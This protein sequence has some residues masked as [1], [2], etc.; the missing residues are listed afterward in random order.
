[1]ARLSRCSLGLR[2]RAPPN[3]TPPADR[4]PQ[5]GR[6][7]EYALPTSWLRKSESVMARADDPGFASGRLLHEVAGDTASTNGAPATPIELS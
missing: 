3:S 2:L 7:G 5:A 6:R 1:M 4:S